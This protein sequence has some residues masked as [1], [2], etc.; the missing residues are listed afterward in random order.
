MNITIT[1]LSDVPLRFRHSVTCHLQCLR[2]VLQPLVVKYVVI[3]RRQCTSVLWCVYHARFV[4]VNCQF[5]T[6]YTGCLLLLQTDQDI[7]SARS[8]PD[9]CLR[10][11]YLLG[12]DQLVLY[13][14]IPDLGVDKLVLTLMITVIITQCFTNVLTLTLTVSNVEPQG[15]LCLVN[16]SYLAT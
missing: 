8:R 15:F 14:I 9:L 2:T 16:N 7:V 13:L 12:V 10:R 6:F 11:Q 1:Q 5:G 3:Q 4:S